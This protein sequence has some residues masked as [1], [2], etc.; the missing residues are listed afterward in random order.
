[1]MVVTP[2]EELLLES[3]WNLRKLSV[4]DYDDNTTEPTLGVVFRDTYFMVANLETFNMYKAGGTFKST[5]EENMFLRKHVYPYSYVLKICEHIP[6]EKMPTKN[7]RKFCSLYA[8][9][10]P[11]INTFKK[12]CTNNGIKPP[13]N[14]DYRCSRGWLTYPGS[15][16]ALGRKMLLIDRQ[17]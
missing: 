6:F 4:V 8:V 5:L 3:Y 9:V 14:F 12:T 15:I 7:I 13:L 1:M 16:K 2:P 11:S 10:C 17:I